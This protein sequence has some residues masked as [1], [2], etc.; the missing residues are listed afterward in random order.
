MI[1]PSDIPPE[2]R[3]RLLVHVHGGCYVLSGGES[4]TS[5]AIYM[6]AF[7]HFKVLSVDYRRPPG[8]PLSRRPG[9][10]DGG[11]AGRR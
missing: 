10:C 6:A 3:N 1:T 8:V 9:R 5:E 2:N 11:V 7:G 4:G